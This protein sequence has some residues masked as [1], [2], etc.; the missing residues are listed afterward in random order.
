MSQENVEIVRRSMEAFPHDE[1]AWLSAADPGIVW[2]PIE[3]AHT[4]SRGHV[5]AVGVRRRWLENWE[6]FQIDVEEMKDSA[7]SV[8]ACLHLT[9]QGKR[10]GVEVD[11]RVWVHYK[12]RDGKVVYVYEY[13]DRDAAL[14]AA[15]IS[16]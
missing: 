9:G 7:D 4:P 1:E 10:S 3:E 6:A 14:E 8:V 12:L 2:H 16:G 5:A 13:A 15:G 11:L